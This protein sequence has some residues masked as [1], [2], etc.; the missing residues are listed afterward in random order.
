MF[1]SLLFLFIFICL[2]YCFIG[3]SARYMAS[4]FYC[5]S[6]TAFSQDGGSLLISE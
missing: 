1:L 2:F 6:R 3:M 5:L 4:V